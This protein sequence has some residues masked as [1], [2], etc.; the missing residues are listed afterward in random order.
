MRDDRHL[1]RALIAGEL[2]MSRGSVV[3][4]VVTGCVHV[5]V[6]VRRRHALVEWKVEKSCFLT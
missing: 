2:L 5:H 3:V 1:S 6:S 4:V